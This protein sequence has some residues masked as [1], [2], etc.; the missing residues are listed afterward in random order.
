MERADKLI[1][2]ERAN[3]DD[4]ESI[5]SLVNYFADQDLMLHRELGDIRE[6]IGDYFV[7][8]EGSEVR[9]CGALHV[10][11]KDCLAEIRAVAVQEQSQRRGI[12]RLIVRACLDKAQDEGISQVF[13][14]TYRPEVFGRFGFERTMTVPPRK[15][16][17]ECATCPKRPFPGCKEI[18]MVRDLSRP[19][20]A[21]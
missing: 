19:Q 6:N 12:S 17:G 8:R 11:E 5:Q 20:L 14:L 1:V 2:A 18:P 9:G 7:Y 10:L 3:L 13:L 4:A 16:L 15:L 21:A